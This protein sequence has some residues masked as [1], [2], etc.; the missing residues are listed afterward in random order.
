M[1]KNKSDNGKLQYVVFGIY[2]LFL[3]WLVLFKFS[4]SSD[5]IIQNR[6]INLIPFS[7]SEDSS[8]RV[9]LKEF[10]YNVLVFVPLGTYL[11]VVFKKWSFLKKTFAAL[12]I[13]FAFE[14]IQFVF[15]L[16]ISDITDLINNTAGAV[17]G[18]GIYCILSLLFKEKTV[19]L[20]N[21]IGITAEACFCVL[22]LLLILANL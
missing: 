8:A 13:S 18:I 21:I 3:V 9:V 14:V 4:T 16:G 5:S 20:L 19:K 15:A 1:I 7:S 2:L 11:S 12:C 6:G 17:A 22:F 10:I